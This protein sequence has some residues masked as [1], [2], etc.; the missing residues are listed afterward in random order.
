MT[1]R[2]DYQTGLNVSSGLSGTCA[3]RGLNSS[4]CGLML[5]TLTFDN[6]SLFHF[7]FSLV[8]GDPP[9]SDSGFSAWY[10]GGTLH[11]IIAPSVPDVT[12]NALFGLIYT[13]LMRP[14]CATPSATSSPSSNVQIFTIFSSPAVT[15]NSPVLDLKVSYK[16]ISS[17][18]MVCSSSAPFTLLTALPFTQFQNVI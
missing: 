7:F 10:S 3:P 13:S 15:K 6:N 5:T 1:T 17:A 8:E 4:N 2:C 11:I 16:L 9:Y 14:K 12:I 18:T